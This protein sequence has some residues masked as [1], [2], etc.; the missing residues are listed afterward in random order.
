MPGF[1]VPFQQAWRVQRPRRDDD[2]LACVHLPELRRASTLALL[3]VCV[4]VRAAYARTHTR[5]CAVP[6][7]LAAGGTSG[8]GSTHLR[9]ALAGTSGVMPTRSTPRL[10]WRVRTVS[11]CLAPCWS[12]AVPTTA[13]ALHARTRTREACAGSGYKVARRVRARALHG[14]G[15]GAPSS[16]GGGRVQLV[17]DTVNLPAPVIVVILTPYPF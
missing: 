15:C 8:T 12:T 7:A 4:R 2:A 10:C 6:A 17:Q 13:C 1:R 3:F 16:G 14:W 9:A 11:E 5:W